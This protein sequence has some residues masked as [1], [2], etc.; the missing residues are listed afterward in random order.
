MKRIKQDTLLFLTACVHPKGMAQTALQDGDVRLRQYLDAIRFYLDEYSYK[1]L[2]VENTEVDLS[3]YFQKEIEQGRLECMT[4]DGN[5][6]DRSLGKGYG[7]GLIINYAFSHSQFIK[8]CKFLIKVSGRHRVLNLA[9]I[10]KASEWFLNKKEDLVVCEI[11]PAKNFARSDCYIASKSFYRRYLNEGLLH[12]DDSKDV[13]FE[14]ILYKSIVQACKAGFQFLYIPFALDQ[15]G[16]SGTSGEKIPKASL[17]MKLHFFAKMLCYK[18][19][20]RKIW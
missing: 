11:N 9:S 16:D 18:I 7:E 14:H 12:C 13:W 15:R 6:F 10:M 4:F 1:I 20:N 19:L 2:V 8:E 5:S 17:K 3:P